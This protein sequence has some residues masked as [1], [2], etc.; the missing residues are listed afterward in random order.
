MQ[1]AGTRSKP[2]E[3]AG[4]CTRQQELIAEAQTHLIRLAELARQES[5]AIANRNENVV[6]AIDKEI[7]NALG[8]KERSLGALHE[9]REEHGC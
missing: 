8:A 5:E 9:H 3:H 7:E 1:M 4:P 6:L 2:P